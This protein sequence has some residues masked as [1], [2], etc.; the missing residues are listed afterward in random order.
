MVKV[1]I[2]IIL[3]TDITIT[4]DIIFYL[5][6]LVVTIVPKSELKLKSDSS[7]SPK[8]RSVMPYL[9]VFRFEHVHQ[10]HQVLVLVRHDDLVDV[11]Q[12]HI[13]GPL[14]R[15]VNALVERGLL[16]KV[17]HVPAA[18]RMQPAIR[19]NQMLVDGPW[20][21]LHEALLAVALQQV[22]ELR[23]TASVV[24]HHPVHAK[25]PGAKGRERVQ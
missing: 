10:R 13:A 24:D 9:W 7:P 2:T 11:I 21:H 20:D 18:L 16:A 19:R 15:S 17:V 22:V 14:H 5:N 1:I 25:Q 4:C 12:Q 8:K 6:D 3:I 23:A